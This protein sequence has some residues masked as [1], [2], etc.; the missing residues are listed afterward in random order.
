MPATTTTA[1]AAVWR[2]ASVEFIA[3]HPKRASTPRADKLARTIQA[4]LLSATEA[5]RAMSTLS[6]TAVWA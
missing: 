3:K 6:R 1:G 5:I 4:L 2:D